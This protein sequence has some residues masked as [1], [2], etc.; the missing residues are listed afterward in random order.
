MLRSR[1]RVIPTY[2][3][4]AGVLTDED[5]EVVTVERWAPY[6]VVA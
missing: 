4:A 6:A 2:A 3:D 1:P 5:W